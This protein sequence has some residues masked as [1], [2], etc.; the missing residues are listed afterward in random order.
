M[1]F[2]LDEERAAKAYEA[3]IKYLAAS[4]RSEKEC[5]E[6][7]Y[8]KGYHKSEVDFAIDKAKGYRYINDEEYVRTYL[9]FN[10][11]RYGS[12]KL[13]YKL[14][15]EKGIDKRIVDNIISDLI[16]EDSERAKCAE[17]ARAYVK[18]KRMTDRSEAHK[19]AAYLYQKGFDSHVISSIM[20]S[21]FDVYGDDE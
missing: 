21:L 1:E 14:T 8:E 15:Q 18:K 11:G 4:P 5:R 10:G 9:T 16:S 2:V 3:L 6:K 12:K 20:A 19:V 7:L 17:F 13:A